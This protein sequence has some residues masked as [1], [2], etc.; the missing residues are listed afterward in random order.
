ME[1]ST[2]HPS[3]PCPDCTGK[4][5]LKE[6]RYGLAYLCENWPACKGA[7]GAHPDGKPLGTPASKETRLARIRAHAAFDSTWRK[8]WE[9]IPDYSDVDNSKKRRYL[10]RVA[11]NRSYAWLREQLYL[12]ED[13]CHIGAFSIEKC[14]SVVKA[15]HGVTPLTIRQ[16]HKEQVPA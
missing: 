15:C 14:N 7:H 5:Y 10:E 11:R 4:L 9:H 16:W 2:I 6:T 8:P 1:S 3:L 13:E 12:T